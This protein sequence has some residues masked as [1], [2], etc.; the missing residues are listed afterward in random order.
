M[1]GPRIVVTRSRAES[2]LALLRRVGELSVPDH[3][4]PFTRDEL[5]AAV[6]GASALVTVLND[7]VD[8]ELLDAAGPGL[9]IVANTAAGYDNLDL[10]ELD[11]RGVIASNT[12]GILGEATAELTLTLMLTLTR[13]LLEGD[14]LIRSKE[15]W[16]WDLGFMLGPGLRDA[17][18][19]IVGFGEIGR[20]VA[21]LLPAFGANVIFTS[22]RTVENPPPGS[23]QVTLPQLLEV[24]DIVSLH[25]P[26]T[27]QTHHLIDSAALGRM[28]PTAWL[29]N[30]A[31]GPIIDEGALVEALRTGSIAGAALDVY[32][33]EPRVLPAL[34][35]FEN[36]V[37]TPHLGSATP[38]TRRRMADAAA[39][40][41]VAAL[42][43]REVPNAVGQ[44]RRVV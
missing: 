17:T 39:A 3:N 25:C 21:V 38:A 18:V 22:R 20:A 15:D 5:L 37:L 13:R 2:S 10:A 14:R 9:R 7:H 12:P 29:V 27:E 11:R 26:L 30:T 40:N 42:T 24:A 16:E 31:R 1:T 35:S 6:R 34:T 36:V 41:V 4:R 23:R 8:D 19:G 44:H 33:F 28:K 43:G 32:E